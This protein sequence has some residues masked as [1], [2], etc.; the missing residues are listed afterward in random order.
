M[1]DGCTQGGGLR[2]RHAAAEIAS[3]LPNLMFEVRAERL[4]GLARL[5]GAIFGLEA[6]IFHGVQLGHLLKQLVTLLRIV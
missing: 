1:G 6:A 5:R 2:G 4:S 3:L